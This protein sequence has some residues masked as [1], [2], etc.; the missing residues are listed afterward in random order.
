MR[1]PDVELFVKTFYYSL[2]C[3]SRLTIRHTSH[4]YQKRFRPYFNSQLGIIV[5]L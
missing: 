2:V 1:L 3:P 4:Y 5:K